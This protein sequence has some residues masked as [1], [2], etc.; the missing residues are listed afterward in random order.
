MLRILVPLD[1]SALAES[2]LPDA[3]EL[4]GAQGELVL[5][6]VIRSP[7]LNR[8]TDGFTRKTAVQDSNDYLISRATPIREQGLAVH[9]RTLV[10]ADVGAAIDET[11][12]SDAVDMIACATHG[13]GPA[14]R[15]MHGSVT[16]KTVA[17]SAVPVF[18]RHVD[19]ETSCPAE[20]AKGCRIMVPL[21]GS[22]Y[23]EKALPVA[24]WLA[25]RWN[26]PLSLVRVVEFAFTPFAYASLPPLD[27]TEETA[28]S[29]RYLDGIALGP[30][31]EVERHAWD[32]QVVPELVN[33][34]K[35]HS[36]THVVMA[37]HGRTAMSRVI[38]GSVADGLVHAL[39]CPIIVIPALARGRI[40]DHEQQSSPRPAVNGSRE[41]LPVS[42][43]YAAAKSK[44]QRGPNIGSSSEAMAE[45]RVVV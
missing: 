5:L 4:A 26:A 8:G 41:A 15:L 31:F 23:A 11:A 6:H 19:G 39:H 38:L 22:A 29:K 7:N 13:R 21:D 20:P 32:G 37:S 45:P 35:E 43:G 1:G 44:P 14:G 3:R 24:E 18:L 28:A 33:F 27:Y 12:I 10:R 30:S 42:A 36:I 16:W 2:I 40:E 25:M 34:A 9:I 17:N